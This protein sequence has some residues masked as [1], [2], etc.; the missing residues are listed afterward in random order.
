MS[1]RQ[2]KISK[3]Q[4]KVRKLEKQYEQDKSPD[5]RDKLVRARRELAKLSGVSLLGSLYTSNHSTYVTGSNRTTS[6]CN[7]VTRL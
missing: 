4:G 2:A 3:M 7:D 1:S 5:T 6:K